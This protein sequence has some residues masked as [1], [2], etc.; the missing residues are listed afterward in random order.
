MQLKE[1]AN[2]L[3]IS[4]GNLQN[5]IFD[6]GV[7]LAFAIDKDFQILPSFVDFTHKHIDFIKK[8]AQDRN[9]IKSIEDIATNLGV[10]V[11][12]IKN[13][14]LQNG[15][16][17]EKLSEVKTLISSFVIHQY[18]GG[19]YDF[20][21]DD[22]P[23]VLD[24]DGLIGYTDMY[25]FITDMLDPFINKDHRCLWGITRPM[26][27]ILYGPPGSGKTFWAQKIA[28]MI[29]YQFVHIFKDYLLS[30]PS[31]H[32]SHFN[33]FLK[34]KINTPKTLIFI[35]DFDEMMN[36]EGNYPHSP[37]SIELVNSIVR[38]IQKDNTQEL[39]L[40]GSAEILSSLNE[41]IT[42]PGR[43]DLH[44]PIFPPNEQERVELIIFNLTNNLNE[45]SPLL[46][47]LKKSQAL[48]FDFWLPYSRE[49]KLF[50][51]TMIIDF[52]QSIKKRLY[53]IYRK[54]ENQSIILTPQIIAAAFNEAKMKSSPEYLKLCQVFV[55][56]AKQ[57]N[58]QEFPQR[59]M[60]I[61]HELFHF[62]KK[63]EKI[64][65]IGFNARNE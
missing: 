63:E 23:E 6:F 53:A 56:E 29:G 32:S 48:S 1:L 18:L 33:Q 35:D 52:T 62:V 5:F 44:L 37:E 40:V 64:N 59:I 22:L 31:T 54:D 13:F 27:I 9:Q 38:L 11:A 42:A 24:N 34:S 4:L 47:I 36:R 51:N 45:N 39:V 3:D 16:P 25:F 15:V 61:E 28:Q 21:F 14:F 12:I 30:T 2:Q 7:P 41:E 50:S 20:I 46:K 8:Y 17:E 60:D 65:K 26:G 19:N 43:F 55:Q 49:M 57:N 10:D 58:L